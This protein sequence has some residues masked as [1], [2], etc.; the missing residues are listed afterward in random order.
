MNRQ[1]KRSR[2][3]GMRYRE[4]EVEDT[5][6]VRNVRGH[7]RLKTDACSEV[8]Y[9]ERRKERAGFHRGACVAR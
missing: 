4:I 9:V 6:W 1:G 8:D 3:T 7:W 5:R 2:W